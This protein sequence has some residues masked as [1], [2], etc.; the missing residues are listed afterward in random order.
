MTKRLVFV[1]IVISLLIRIAAAVYLG[2]SADPISGASDQQSYDVLAQ[3]VLGGYGFSFPVR[4]YPFTPP[5]EPTAHWSYLYTLYLAAVYVVTGHHPIAARLIQVLLSA[6]NLWLVYRIGKRL[7]GDTV[8]V[9]AAALTGFYAYLIFFNAALM[10]QTFYILFLLAGIDLALQLADQPT[11]KRWILLGL[12][13]GIGALVRQ[14]L[15]LF[16]PLLFAWIL[17]TSPSSRQWRHVA[18]SLALLAAVILPWTAY[19]YYTFHD[20]LLLNSNSGYWLYSSNHPNQ[21]TNFDPNYVAPIPD[22]LRA[23]SEPAIDRALTRAALGF[24]LS[25]PG[26]FVLLSLNRTK[27]YFWLVPSEQS[28]GISNL[29]R[30]F[31]FTLYLP[32]ML[33]GLYLSRKNWRACVP[34]YLYVAFDTSLSLASWSAPRYRLPADSLMMIYA[35]LAVQDIAERTP[36][37][38]WLSGLHAL[39]T[40]NQVRI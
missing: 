31:S 34:L 21:G 18:G 9:L 40:R 7:F 12:V 39:L 32:F 33:Y 30:L 37:P 24:V 28:S 35:G 23:L 16:A 26:R 22:D 2:D 27:D 4:W 6:L 17:W 13:I 19:N 14:T 8:G 36:I 29:S 5:N 11:L 15:L 20:F 25:D 38:Q 1:V 3:R 10:T